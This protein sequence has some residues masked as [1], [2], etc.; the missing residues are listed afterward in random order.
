MTSHEL[1]SLS[2]ALAALV[3]AAAAVGGWAGLGQSRAVITATG[4]AL[5][6][7]LIVGTVIAVV[8]RTPALAPVY[9]VVMVVAGTWTSGRRVNAGRY[10]FAAAGVSIAAG[11]TLSALVVFS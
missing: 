6:Q 3:L 9:L 4:R 5:V 7:L 10:G 11:A 8:V 2:G 1:I